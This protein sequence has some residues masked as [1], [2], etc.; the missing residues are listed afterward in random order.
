MASMDLLRALLAL[1]FVIG[2][3]GAAAWAARRFAP[4]TL[5]AGKSKGQRR[6]SVVESLS[7]DARHRLVLVRRD[8]RSHLLLIGAGQCQVV[9]GSITDPGAPS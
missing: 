3:I 4:A 1:V 6:L 8:D 9:E 7:I 2:L 5:F